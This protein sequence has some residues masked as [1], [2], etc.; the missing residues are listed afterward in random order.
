MKKRWVLDEREIRL[1]ERK[2]WVFVE[3]EIWFDIEKKGSDMKDY[4][5]KW[6]LDEREIRQKKKK[7][8]SGP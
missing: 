2:L 3:R 1:T 4:E 6:V 7:K 5:K 8:I